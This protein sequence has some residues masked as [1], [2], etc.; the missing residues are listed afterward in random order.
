MLKNI[1]VAIDGSQN[2]NRAFNQA[3]KL[4][5]TQKA[6]LYL[7]RV[8]ED[9]YLNEDDGIL[10]MENYSDNPE[11]IKARDDLNNKSLMTVFPIRDTFLRI[12]DPKKIIAT[13]LVR[14]LKIDL[15][16]VGRFG[17][18]FINRKKIGSNANF[19]KQN[20]PCKVR[21]IE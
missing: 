18:D 11:V 7:V 15:L 12:G 10:Q 14:G 5:Q 19:F 13:Y 17:K 9:Y 16:V 6:N 4:A 8:V 20:A 1:L 2:S 21:I 3:L